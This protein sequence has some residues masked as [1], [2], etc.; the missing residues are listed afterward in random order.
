MREPVPQVIEGIDEYFV[1]HGIKQLVRELL[2]QL[3]YNQPEDPIEFMQQFL[4]NYTT[5]QE[6]NLNPSA[7]KN[8]D[9]Q[10]DDFMD[11]DDYFLDDE[12]EI[13]GEEPPKPVMRSRRGGVS[14]APIDVTAPFTFTPIKKPPEMMER[15]R[16]AVLQNPLLSEVEEKDRE[17]V[18]SAMDIISYK[19]TE[20]IITQG[21][22][23]DEYFIMD[24]GTVGVYIRGPNQ[25]REE[26]GNEVIELQAPQAFGELALMFQQPRAASIVAKTDVVC[27][28]ITGEVY[29][30]IIMMA[31]MQKRQKF[32]DF[33]SQVPLFDDLIDYEVSALADALI[34]LNVKKGDDIVKQGDSGAH[35]YI[36]EEGECVVHKTTDEHPEGIE[37]LRL[38]KNDFFGELALLYN[39]PRA[40]TVTALTDC[41]IIKLERAA[42]DR[43]L[44]PVDEYL[45]RNRTKYLY[46]VEQK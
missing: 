32:K 9:P 16:E 7:P 5:T 39:K 14:S 22:D 12:D 27:W 13:L 23:G 37:V 29:R 46:Y 40:A 28:S 25:P 33:L 41:T 45:S 30:R 38:G 44:G 3:A 15:L 34:S 6:V 18:I 8:T 11:E 26:L 17:I 31:S 2:S 24:S 36:I 19:P 1:T 43:L 20:H 42:F 21:D 10:P 35:F 4:S